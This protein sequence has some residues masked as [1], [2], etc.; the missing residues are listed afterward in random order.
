MRE[1]NL[2]PG[3]MDAVADIVR[4]HPGGL[5][6]FELMQQLDRHYPELYPKPDLRDPLL[7]FQH[8]F[9]L[10]HVLYLLQDE[11]HRA[12][13]GVL[14]I[15]ALRIVARRL[16]NQG[17]RSPS[18][19]TSLRDYYLDWRNLTRENPESVQSLID[20]FWKRL[21]GEQKSPDALAE[22]GLDDSADTA[23]IKSRYRQLASEH[24]PDKGG[25]PEEFRR[26][27]EAY[28]AL[29]VTGKH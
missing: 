28:E 18:V 1:L 26:I 14:E 20:G 4:R 22:L 8:H 27:R 13:D 21:L 2:P 9:I 29:V 3:L 19:N 5:S 17:G 15:N 23:R 16:L 24:H 10:M 11:W 25:D 7:L 6:E 12:G